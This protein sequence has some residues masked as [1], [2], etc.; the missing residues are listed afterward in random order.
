MCTSL[1]AILQKFARYSV[2]QEILCNTG[3][4]GKFG[5]F[6]QFWLIFLKF[7]KKNAKP[8]ILAILENIEQHIPK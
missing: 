8:E 2:I 1:L 6:Y 7:G 5:Q 4:F 3:N